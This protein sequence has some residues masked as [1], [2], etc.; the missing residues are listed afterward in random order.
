MLLPC[1]QSGSRLRDFPFIPSFLGFFFFLIMNGKKIK[2]KTKIMNGYWIF[3]SLFLL[4]LICLFI[5]NSKLWSFFVG[6]FLIRNLIP[7]IVIGLFRFSI[8][9]WPHFDN[10]FHSNNLPIYLSQTWEFLKNI[11]IKGQIVNI[12]GFSGHLVSVVIAQFFV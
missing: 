6:R 5:L 1:S 11:Y 12:L 2:I 7:L 9:S 8:S 3:P 4:L 10:L